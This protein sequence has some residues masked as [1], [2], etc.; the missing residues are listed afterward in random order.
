MQKEGCHIRGRGD[1][2]KSSC[3]LVGLFQILLFI[4]HPG[5]FKMCLLYRSRKCMATP[6]KTAKANKMFRPR[7]LPVHSTKRLRCT[8]PYS[9]QLSLKLI[10]V[11][12]RSIDISHLSREFLIELISIDEKVQQMKH[13]TTVA[14]FC[15][16][17]KKTG[18]ESH[19]C[20]LHTYS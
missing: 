16:F 6:L 14:L 20:S 18:N 11:D 17:Y 5:N 10:S 8:Q 15:T 7:C 9:D 4:C 3:F 12:F 2:V 1:A 13:Q 19:V